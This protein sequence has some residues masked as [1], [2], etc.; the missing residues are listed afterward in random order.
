MQS[1]ATLN[2]LRALEGA[3]LDIDL[4]EITSERKE[5]LTKSLQLN[6]PGI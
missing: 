6:H 3:I 4:R 5:Q 1:K 2:L